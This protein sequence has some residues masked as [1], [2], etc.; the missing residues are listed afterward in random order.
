MS[1]LFQ[2]IKTVI[3]RLDGQMEL[4]CETC[5]RTLPKVYEDDAF[6]VMIEDAKEARWRIYREDGKWKHQ[7]PDCR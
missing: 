5:P 3:E 2:E 6:D 7:C 1:N 4:T